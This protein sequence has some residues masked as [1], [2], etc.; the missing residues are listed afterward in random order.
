MILIAAHKLPSVME[1]FSPASLGLDLGKGFR[2]LRHLEQSTPAARRIRKSL[3]TLSRRA[4]NSDFAHTRPFGFS[5]GPNL[6]VIEEHDPVLRDDTPD[7][8]GEFPTSLLETEDSSWFD[9]SLFEWDASRW[10]TV[11]PASDD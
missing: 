10:E 1:R 6:G 5:P 8:N 4:P 9:T 7:S 11:S 3:E 2:T